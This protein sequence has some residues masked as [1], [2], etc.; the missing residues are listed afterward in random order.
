M[1][2]PAL[3]VTTR[4]WLN[5]ELQVEQLPTAFVPKFNKS[6]NDVS[7]LVGTIERHKAK[8]QASLDGKV[9]INT[10]YI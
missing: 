1:L 3:N 2:K 7:H 6:M 8:Y 5:D 9:L 10:D 4:C